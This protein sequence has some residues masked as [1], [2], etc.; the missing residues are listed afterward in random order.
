MATVG[1]WRYIRKLDPIVFDEQRLREVARSVSRFV[2]D[3]KAAQNKR[4]EHLRRL[5]YSQFRR[6]R[7]RC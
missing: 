2:D 7:M 1:E 6:A 4:R 5:P 3:Y